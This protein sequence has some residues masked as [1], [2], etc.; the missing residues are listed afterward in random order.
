MVHVLTSAPAGH[1]FSLSEQLAAPVDQI[2]IQLVADLAVD[3]FGNVAG[4]DGSTSAFRLTPAGTLQTVAGGPSPQDPQN[5]REGDSNAI[6]FSNL[7]PIA[8]LP[9]RGMVLIND[10]SLPNYNQS[11]RSAEHFT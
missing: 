9:D 5:P 8:P 4:V 3:A 7:L 6:P 2:S 11:P 1:F 10:G